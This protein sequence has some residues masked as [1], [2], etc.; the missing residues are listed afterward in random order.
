MPVN[1]AGLL[2][3]A[4]DTTRTVVPAEGTGVPAG[5]LGTGTGLEAPGTTGASGTGELTA[6]GCGVEGTLGTGVLAGAS[7]GAGTLMS[8]WLAGQLKQHGRLNDLRR[9]LLLRWIDR[10]KR[11]IGRSSWRSGRR[12][13]RRCRRRCRGRCSGR[14]SRSRRRRK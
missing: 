6:G 1:S 3:V 10:R 11:L 2:T 12:S 4:D 13:G 14:R 9:I 5:G 7:G 8:G